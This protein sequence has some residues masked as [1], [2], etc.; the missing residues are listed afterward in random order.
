LYRRIEVLGRLTVLLWLGILGV[1]AW[2]CIEGALHFDAA[3]AFDF[4]ASR[5]ENMGRPLG[6]AMILAL[7]SYLGYY[8]I[9]YIGEEVRDPGRTVP[10]AILLSA[11]LVCVLFTALQRCWAQCRGPRR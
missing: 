10:R 9:C 3:R 11:V 7:Y 8:N 6:E 4:G 5:P 2:I 1:I